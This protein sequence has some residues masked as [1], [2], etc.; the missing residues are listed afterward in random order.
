MNEKTLEIL[1]RERENKFSFEGVE[2]EQL[3]NDLLDNIGH[4]D[5]E[6]R[7]RLIYPC[8]AHLLHDKIFD[9]M[10]LVKITKELISNK[11]LTYDL[12]NTEEY[13]VLRRSFTLLQL[14]ILVYVHNRDGLFEDSLFENI[15]DNFMDYFG[16][17]LILTGYKKEVGWMHSIAHSADLFAQIFKSKELKENQAE[18]AMISIRDKFV[19]SSYNYVSDEGERM[20][21][22]IVN[23]IK[24]EILSQEFW[25]KWIADFETYPKVSDYPQVYILKNNRKYLLSALYFRLSSVPES[26]YLLEPL[27]K[28]IIDTEAIK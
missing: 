19:I 23:L 9:N 13:S 8:L 16:K 18:E 11:Y 6:I 21:T 20:T 27:K 2:K 25:L 17:E 1:K 3:L 15:Y 10:L 28:A 14:V 4:L 24:R 7:D 12:E 22:A 26:E 5:S